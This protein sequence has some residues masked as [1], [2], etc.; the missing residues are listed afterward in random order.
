VLA[1][2][3]KLKKEIPADLSLRGTRKMLSQNIRACWDALRA[4]PD[5][6]VFSALD[7][8]KVWQRYFVEKG[9]V[10]FTDHSDY[11]QFMQAFMMAGAEE[12]WMTDSLFEAYKAAF[13][14]KSLSDYVQSIAKAITKNR[15]KLKSDLRNLVNADVHSMFLA[16]VKYSLPSKLWE[17]MKGGDPIDPSEVG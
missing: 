2:C 3:V 1:A 4:N 6:V 15:L 10:K 8:Q 16:A 17:E 11:I 9:V 12:K 7:A 14:P 13:F 5:L